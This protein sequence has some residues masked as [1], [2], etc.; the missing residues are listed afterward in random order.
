MS[1]QEKLKHLPA[2]PGV[3]L[4]KSNDGQILYV[5]KAVNLR[6]R[7]RSYFQKSRHQSPRIRLLVEQIADLDYIVTDSELE[8][9]ILENNLIKE[10]SPWFNVRLKDDKTYPYI[11]VTVNED[12]P[13]VLFVRRRLKDGARYYGPYTN[14]AAVRNTIKVLRKL[15]Q[16]RTCSKVIKEGQK[17][18]PCLNYHIGRCAGPCAGLISKADYRAIVDEVCLFLEGRHE[19]LIP[20]MRAKML[21][22]S[23]ELKFEQAARIR[24]RID[25]L[26]QIVARQKIVSPHDIDQDL[27]GLAR[28][29]DLACVQVFFVRGGKLIGRDHFILDC[30][31]DDS[32]S[33]ILTAF[34]KQYYTDQVM[35]PKEVLTS[36]ALT[37]TELLSQWLSELRGSK[38]YFHHPRR[39]EKKALIEMV[40]ANAQ[41]VL[42]LLRSQ[43]ER[44][45]QAI[46][47]GLWE[48]AHLVGLTEPPRRIEAYDISNIQGSQI[49][50]SMVVM[51]DGKAAAD[52]YRRFKIQSLEGIPNDY[53]A[54]QEVIRRRFTRGLR[55][56][57]GEIESTAF[58]EFPD[59]VVI[60]GGKGQLSS[61]VAVR[62]QLELT[63]P[64]IS[65]AE[66]HEEIYL[67]GKSS[68]VILPP[69]SQGLHLVQRIRDEAHRFA[70]TYHR[71]LRSKTSQKSVLDQIPGVGP[72]RKKALLKHFG[73]VKKIKAATVEQLSEVEGIN[74]KLAREIYQFMHEQ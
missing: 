56:H 24:D 69:E 25:S 35:I 70:L 12:F 47:R 51:I 48:L 31:L 1:L 46:T 60:D 21:Q 36:E 8:A 49:V 57:Q 66:K 54:M 53:L 64:F 29:E 37:E 43:E 7:V 62:D 68:P 63:M 44:K 26:E 59:L 15:F 52:Q 14:A 58:S 65:L 5:G 3:Y 20:S 13:R 50:A 34:I 45:A 61:A 39:G 73:S 4:M 23:A 32:P 10:H 42:E 11:K 67:E 28:D 27:F 9:L 71:Q 18:R 41:D 16:I 55:E 2:K 33:E 72:Q 17:D 40:I 22:A 38:V 19:D 6:N 74:P 30:S